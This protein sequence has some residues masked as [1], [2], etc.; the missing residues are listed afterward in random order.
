MGL[1]KG[2]EQLMKHLW[3]LEE[4]FMKDLLDVLPDPK[5]ATT[6]VATLLRRMMDKGMVAYRK[7]GNS[8]QYYPLISKEDYFAPQVKNMISDFF[9]DSPTEFASFFTARAELSREELEQLRQ[10]I[11]DQLNDPS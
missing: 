6:T 5:P 3:E 10:L 7:Y 8:R 11:D 2:E 9:G 4:A 1:S